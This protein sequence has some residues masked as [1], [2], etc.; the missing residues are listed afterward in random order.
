MIKNNKNIDNFVKSFF[1]P[2]QKHKNNKGF[3]IIDLINIPTKE[4]V[5][6]WINEEPLNYRH[7][8]NIKIY[9]DSNPN[10]F[11]FIIEFFLNSCFFS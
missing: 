5:F 9:L 4:Q 7:F 3:S 1:I 8:N 11:Q 10:D 2:E 6:N